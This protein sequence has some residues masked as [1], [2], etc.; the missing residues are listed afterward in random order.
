VATTQPGAVQPPL[1]PTTSLPS[2][3]GPLPTYNEATQYR[4]PSVT[5]PSYPPSTTGNVNVTSQHATNYSQ[6]P[7][8]DTT[9]ERS[10]SQPS[11]DRQTSPPTAQYEDSAAHAVQSINLG[12]NSQQPAAQV[13]YSQPPQQQQQPHFTSQA[14]P[15]QNTPPVPI[16]TSTYQPYLAYGAPPSSGT[17]ETYSSGQQ[18][19]AHPPPFA[20]HEGTHGHPMPSNQTAPSYAF[21]PYQPPAMPS[22]NSGM[23]PP[24]TVPFSQPNVAYG[25]PTPPPVSFPMPPLSSLGIANLVPPPPSSLP[26]VPQ[27]QQYGSQLPPQY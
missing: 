22:M 15:A 8:V 1:A 27:Q 4:P 9:N 24:P 11:Y 17:A 18:Y 19:N 23:P 2:P 10:A 3:P 14:P 20:G 7:Q 26:S 13:N 6:Q 16:Q 12:D 21:Q 25:Q 5:Q